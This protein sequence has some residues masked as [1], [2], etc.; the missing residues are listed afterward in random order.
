MF[1]HKHPRTTARGTGF[2]RRMAAATTALA[3]GGAFAIAGSAPAMAAEGP[4][5]HV[6]WAQA[7]FLSGAIAGVDLDTVASVEPAEAWSDGEGPTMTDKDPLAVKA[8]NTVQVGTGDPV[9]VNVDGVQAGALG[10]FASASADGQSFAATGAVLDDGAVGIGEDVATPGANAEIDLNG[11]LGSQFASNLADLSLTIEAIAAQAQADGADASGDYRLDG[12]VLHVKSPAISDLTEKVNTA[13]DSISSRVANLDGSDG[14]LLAVVNGLLQKIS[15][16]LSLLGAD[17]SVSATINMGDLR[18]EVEDLL[19]S[20]YGGSGVSFDLETG[21]IL[22][23][24]AKIHGGDLNDL[25]VGT[26]LLSSPIINAVLQSITG[27]VTLI[28]DQVVNRVKDVLNAATVN[29]H[30]NVDLDVAQSPL[31]KQVCE[32]VQQVI[33]VPTNVIERVTIQVPVVDGVVAQVV[34]GVPM[35]NGV[36]IVGN[37][38]GGSLGG[39]LGGTGSTVTWITQTVDKTVTKLVD[40]TVEKLVCT[41]QVTALPSL[42]T[43]AD[44]DI[45]GTVGEFLAG[46][47]VDAS[48]VIKLLGIVN[49]TFDLDAA[50]GGIADVLIDNLFD[51]DSAISELTDAL[52]TGLVEPAVDGLLDGDAAVGSALTDVLSIKVNLQ[53]LNDG[54]FT[55]TALRVT[56]LGGL[57]SGVGGVGGILGTAVTADGL[58]EVNLAQ[59]SVGPNVTRVE[60]PCVGDCGVGGETTTPT[61]GGRITAL[62]ALAMTGINIVMLVLMVLA[63]LAAGAYLVRENYLRNRTVP[64]TDE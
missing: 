53:E 30:A 4:E 5:G 57:G 23:D 10:Q 3:L 34:N 58:A 27:R 64:P 17:S 38:V 47:D 35:L 21:E 63:L 56:A 39:L 55:Q 11:A 2:G 19:T 42:K 26:E 18:Q 60:D 45:A 54:T 44:I 51:N 15:P 52:N 29:V 37:L 31:V 32:T 12:L 40:Q 20:Q 41:D 49:H 50:T 7:Q 25:P 22:I 13:L 48:A 61:G 24:L 14:D 33:Q 6:S 16:S 8:L 9:Q 28:A 46:S 62:G 59:A 36:P 1:T 43:S